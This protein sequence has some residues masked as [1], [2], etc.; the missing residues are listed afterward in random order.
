ML[1]K[2]LFSYTMMAMP[3]ASFSLTLTCVVTY[4]CV[5]INCQTLTI[6]SF[7]TSGIITKRLALNSD[8]GWHEITQRGNIEGKIGDSSLFSINLLKVLKR[9]R[10]QPSHQNS[11]C[12]RVNV[13]MCEKKE[14]VM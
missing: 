14:D 5:V 7:I 13:F 10:S 3:Q 8:E 1:N 12:L 2:L 9:I 4:I 6:L 11:S